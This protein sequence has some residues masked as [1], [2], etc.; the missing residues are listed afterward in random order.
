MA[1]D[2]FVLIGA[3]DLSELYL[4]LAFYENTENNPGVISSLI[5][6]LGGPR[7]IKTSYGI[8]MVGIPGGDAGKEKNNFG[9][10]FHYQALKIR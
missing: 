8:L 6:Q 10:F 2:H 5:G 1:G 7:K 4:N 9:H 3:H